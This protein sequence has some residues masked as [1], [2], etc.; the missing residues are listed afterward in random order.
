MT[1]REDALSAIQAARVLPVIRAG[2]AEAA[3][4]VADDLAGAGLAVLELT[5]NTPGWRELLGQLKAGRPGVLVGVGTV[6][7]ASCA[8]E[9]LQAGADFLVSPYPSPAV[10]GVAGR[11][12][13]LFI[14]GGFTP[15]E[16]AAVASRGPAK[17]F[18][19]SVGGPSYVR[20][21]LAVLPGARIVPTGGVGLADVG[22]YLDAGAFAVGVGSELTAPGDVGER[23]RALLQEV[24]RC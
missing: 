20:S 15:A 6:T 17:L 12:G 1:T 4:A 8:E 13:V 7:V 18:P 5:A 24:A 3:W 9:A 22:A 19:A 16:I 14:E 10:R 2:S 23:A 21:L 11:A